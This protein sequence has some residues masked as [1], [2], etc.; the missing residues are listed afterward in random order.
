MKMMN[1]VAVAWYR[2]RRDNL[3][4]KAQMILSLLSAALFYT[5]LFWADRPQGQ[6]E[7]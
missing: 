3:V 6:L 2:Y 4:E 5:A 1:K 7:K